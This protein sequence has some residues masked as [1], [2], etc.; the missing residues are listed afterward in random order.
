ML[1]ATNFP[2]VHHTDCHADRGCSEFLR[3]KQQQQQQKA[4]V[5]LLFRL[6]RLWLVSVAHL[7]GTC[8]F[9]FTMKGNYGNDLWCSHVWKHTWHILCEGEVAADLPQVP[10]VLTRSSGR[11]SRLDPTTLRRA[12]R[13]WGSTW[14]SPWMEAT[15]LLLLRLNPSASAKLDY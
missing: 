15:V 12:K 5:R 11:S 4:N 8:T 1:K 9:T 10:P 2:R 6:G 13:T 14:G 3:M 7:T